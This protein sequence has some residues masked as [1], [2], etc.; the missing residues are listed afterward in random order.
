MS[1]AYEVQCFGGVVV[2]RPALETILACSFSPCA[3]QAL[4]AAAVV[5]GYIAGAVEREVKTA[6]AAA[7]LQTAYR[8]RF[9][10]TRPKRSNKE[11]ARRHASSPEAVLKEP[12]N[13]AARTVQGLF[14][15][16]LGKKKAAQRDAARQLLASRQGAS[17]IVT[18]ERLDATL[19][20]FIPV[21]CQKGQKK[22][23]MLLAKRVGLPFS[24][25]M[26]VLVAF[27][28]LA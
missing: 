8:R 24:F 5:L 18:R 16:A 15:V 20:D 10:S 25:A 2:A 17:L 21:V 14:V 3:R 26:A 4:P 13:R 7:V 11:I 12:R 6:T 22:K 28:F 1:S 19:H 23:R 27:L 9:F